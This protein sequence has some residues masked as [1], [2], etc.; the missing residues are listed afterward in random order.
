MAPAPA[1]EDVRAASPACKLPRLW[2]PSLQV[3]GSPQGWQACSARIWA[4]GA[5]WKAALHL[6]S[7]APSRRL[8]QGTGAEGGNFSPEY[9]PCSYC[10]PGSER[11][12]GPWVPLSPRLQSTEEVPAVWG[13]GHL[14]SLRQPEVSARQSGQEPC[15]Q[16]CRGH[17]ETPTVHRRLGHLGGNRRVVRT[18]GLEVREGMAADSGRAVGLGQRGMRGCAFAGVLACGWEAWGWVGLGIRA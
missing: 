6:L 10:L 3:S 5:G 4:P 15:R 14:S 8:K 12:T 9:F 7:W 1:P 16:K 13:A 18:Q 17:W 11:L 2:T